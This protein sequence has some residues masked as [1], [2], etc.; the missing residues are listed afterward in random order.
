[1][2]H[3]KTF[4]ISRFTFGNDMNIPAIKRLLE[5][6][7]LISLILSFAQQPSLRKR[8]NDLIEFPRSPIF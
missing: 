7:F 3:L 6:D 5:V 2:A 1:M 8:A 4:T